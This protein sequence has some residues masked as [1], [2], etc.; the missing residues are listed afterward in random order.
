MAPAI[1][2]IGRLKAERLSVLLLAVG[3]DSWGT[4]RPLDTIGFALSDGALANMKADLPSNWL[5][6]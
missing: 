1:C 5:V 3:L 2:S 6:S 4:D